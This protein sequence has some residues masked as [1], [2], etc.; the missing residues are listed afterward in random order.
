M[1]KNA[2]GKIQR[3]PLRSV[4]KDEARDFT[5]WLESNVDQL[6]EALGFEIEIHSREQNVGSFSLDL[7]GKTINDEIVIIENQLAKSDHTHLG[8]LL[9]YLVNLQA[10][11]AIWINSEPRQEHIN[12]INWLNEQSGAAFYL[13]K[14]EAISINGSAPAPLFTVISEPDEELKSVAAHA[15]ELTDREAFNIQF[16]QSLIKKCEN[17]L[18]N[19]TSRKPSKYHFLG[20]ASGKG[21]L[22]FTFLAT[23]N[24]Y[25]VELYIDIGEPDENER[26]LNEL[27]KHKASIETTLKTSL[28]WDP[29]DEKRACRIRWIIKEVDV[30]EADVDKVQDHLI[31][32]MVAFEKTIKPY[33]QGISAK[34]T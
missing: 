18:P 22:T 26:F 27:E 21:G 14:V 12:V 5:V 16:W 32:S 8:Q 34:R 3:H 20:G 11:V 33:I 25:G 30:T 9:T 31:S 2:I 17:V 19:F 15:R 29:I 10:K 4:W 1:S 28:V 13:V 6:S 7:M 23:R 24:F